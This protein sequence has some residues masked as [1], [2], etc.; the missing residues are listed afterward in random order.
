MKT[1]TFAGFQIKDVFLL[2]GDYIKFRVVKDGKETQHMAAYDYESNQVS[3]S[4]VGDPSYAYAIQKI[5]DQ[6]INS[7]TPLDNNH[8]C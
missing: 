8:N 7:I 3:A 4:D 2:D 6:D 5:V 1:Y